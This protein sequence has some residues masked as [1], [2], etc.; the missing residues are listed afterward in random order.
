M[1]ALNLS[2]LRDKFSFAHPYAPHILAISLFALVGILLGFVR[3]N[4]ATGL[5]PQLDKWVVPKTTKPSV[6]EVNAE[7]IASRLWTEQAR[8]SKKKAEPAIVKKVAPWSFVGTITQGG[9]LVAVIA[10][11]KNKILRL[12]A[13]DLLPGDEKIIEIREGQISFEREGAPQTLKLFVE[14][15]PK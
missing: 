15:K 7:E 4:S 1:I 8:A 11:E 13:S 5:A 12:N 6:A 14:S 2:A 9:H 10:T 3:V